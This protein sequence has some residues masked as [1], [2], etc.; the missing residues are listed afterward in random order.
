MD[1]DHF[2]VVSFVRRS[3]F[4]AFIPSW[5]NTR[6]RLRQYPLYSK[7]SP[8]EALARHISQEDFEKSQIY[9]K[10]KAQFALFSKLFSQCVDSAMLQYGFYA[11]CWGAAGTILAK[12]GYGSDYEVSNTFNLSLYLQCS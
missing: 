2:R 5:L 9:G 12:F 11:W 6:F 3:C 8:P 7:T 1:R 10:D 4:F